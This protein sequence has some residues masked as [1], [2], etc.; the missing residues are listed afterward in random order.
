[1]S[2][3]ILDKTLKY[4][5]KNYSFDNL[6]QSICETIFKD[7]RIF[8]HFIEKWLDNTFEELTWVGGCKSYDFID[9]EGNKYDEKTFTKGG[10]KY[11]PSKM[12]GAGRKFNKEDFLEKANN[13]IYIIVDNTN[14][15]E[16]KIKFKKGSDL[17]KKYPRGNISK[18][19]R[20]EFFN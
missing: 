15:P 3:I 17:I 7:G 4:T 9:N 2:K 8:S 10:C 19:K 12:I 20:T 16:I 18:N 13:L 6:S 1:M 11:M 14:F 5:L